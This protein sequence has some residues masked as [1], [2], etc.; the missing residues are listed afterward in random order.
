ML[1]LTS[2]SSIA[3]NLSDDMDGRFGFITK[4]IG[5]GNICYNSSFNF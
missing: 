5:L 3:G 2:I 4:T 1:S